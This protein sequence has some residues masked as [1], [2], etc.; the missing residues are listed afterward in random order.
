MNPRNRNLLFLA[1]IV[2]AWLVGFMMGGTMR[3]PSAS[4]DGSSGNSR[5]PEVVAEAQ[6]NDR[7]RVGK[8]EPS[9]EEPKIKVPWNQERAE[10]AARSVIR[11]AS[12]PAMIRQSIKLADSLSADDFPM[13]MEAAEKAMGGPEVKDIFGII[14]I[15]RWAELDPKAAGEYMVKNKRFGGWLDFDGSIFWSTWAANDPSA[16]IAFAKSMEDKSNRNTAISGIIETIARRDPD[17]AI[18][19]AKIHAPEEFDGGSISSR[20]SEGLSLQSPELKARKLATLGDNP[21]TNNMISQAVAEWAKTDRLA[22]LAWAGELSNPGAKSAALSGIY[23]Q[24]FETAPQAAASALATNLNDE[25][26]MTELAPV[27]IAAWFD[28]DLTAALAWADKLPDE[29]ARNAAFGAI[30][31]EMGKHNPKV[32]TEW[33][34]SIPAGAAKD[35]AINGYIS[36]AGEKDSAGALA[37]ALSISDD[38]KR[39]ETTKSVL[40]SWFNREPAEAAEWLQSNQS[41][42]PEDKIALLKK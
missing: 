28:K 29:K 5:H 26:N 36:Q 31:N 37:W 35:E 1:L 9:D 17:E 11:A 30:G 8:A 22:A 20:I 16:A 24:W 3:A 7:S 10:A 15:A 32:G 4:P 18:A 25:V 34:D 41:I 33:L 42:S 19:F 6:K 40:K 12:V 27:A 2:S 14:G 13:V 38:S 21:P 39:A 23:R